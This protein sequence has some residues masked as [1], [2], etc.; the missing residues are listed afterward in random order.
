MS[1]MSILQ[2]AASDQRADIIRGAQSQLQ[3]NIRVHGC[4]ALEAAEELEELT[5]KP[6]TPQSPEMMALLEQLRA[7]LEDLVALGGKGPQPRS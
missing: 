6:D 5:R 1:E 2:A 7:S 3:E 4:I